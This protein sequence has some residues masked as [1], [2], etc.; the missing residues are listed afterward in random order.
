[1]YCCKF[2]LSLKPQFENFT[3]SLAD[4]VTNVHKNVSHGQDDDFSHSTNPPVLS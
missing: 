2:A 4:D 3:L 1:M